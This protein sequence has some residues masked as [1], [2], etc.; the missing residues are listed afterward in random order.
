MF[1]IQ[2]HMGDNVFGVFDVF[3]VFDIMRPE[4]YGELISLQGSF[5][6]KT[7]WSLSDHA[8]QSLDKSGTHKLSKCGL[9]EVSANIFLLMNNN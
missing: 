5:G 9:L 2:W 6:E 1:P 3:D 7:K 4:K 8:K